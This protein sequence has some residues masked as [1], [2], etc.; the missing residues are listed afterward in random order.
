VI[1]MAGGA[2]VEEAPPQEFFTAPSHERT[3]KFLGEILP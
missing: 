3:K 2:I 1:F